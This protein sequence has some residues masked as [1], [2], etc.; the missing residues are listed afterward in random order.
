MHSLYTF[1]SLS[2]YLGSNYEIFKTKLLA[3]TPSPPYSQRALPMLALTCSFS[4][5]SD[6]N[7]TTYR[8]RHYI[9]AHRDPC[10]SFPGSIIGFSQ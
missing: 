4:N 6:F 7:R 2:N 10:S 9:A 3:T 8:V 1:S 5:T